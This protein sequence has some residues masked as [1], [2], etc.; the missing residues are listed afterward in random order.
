M[1]A[2]VAQTDPRNRNQ[3]ISAPICLST[4]AHQKGKAALLTITVN[5]LQKYIGKTIYF[6]LSTG[7]KQH[8]YMYS[9]CCQSGQTTCHML[10]SSLVPSEGKGI[11]AAR[12]RPKQNTGR[13]P[14]GCPTEGIEGHDRGTDGGQD[15][16]EV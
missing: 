2:G 11:T 9:A 15:S 6:V 12:P 16:K 5:V 10:G 13:A 1:L 8:V 14:G 7:A 3:P 4:I